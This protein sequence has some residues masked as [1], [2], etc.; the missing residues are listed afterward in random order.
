MRGFDQ[1]ELEVGR[2]TL[3]APAH[4]A[5]ASAA[6]CAVAA[7]VAF[8]DRVG[9]QWRDDRPKLVAWFQRWQKRDSF[10]KTRP[11]T[12]WKTGEAGDIDF[13]REVLNGKKGWEMDL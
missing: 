5:P 2:G 13:G 7:C 6:E 11:D 8:L 12:D 1:L 10:M 4:N 3:Q 9:I